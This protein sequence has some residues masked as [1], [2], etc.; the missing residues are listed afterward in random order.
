MT[1]LSFYFHLLIG[2]GFSNASVID[3]E[4]GLG[5]LEA[6]VISF[7]LTDLDNNGVVEI[8]P[9]ELVVVVVHLVRA[10]V[11]GRGVMP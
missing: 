6:S 8:N 2:K 9:E 1:E 5:I 3:L 11:L 10:L 7:V 4:G